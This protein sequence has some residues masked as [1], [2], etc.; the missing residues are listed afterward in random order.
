[1]L[2]LLP[3]LTSTGRGSDVMVPMALPTVGGMTVAILTMLTT[4]VLFCLVEELRHKWSGRSQRTMH[5]V[6]GK[7]ETEACRQ[8][9]KTQQ[10]RLALS[11]PKVNPKFWLK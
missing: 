8:Q 6:K 7:I 3:V 11:L 2:A 1:V 10:S 4:P 5:S 9:R